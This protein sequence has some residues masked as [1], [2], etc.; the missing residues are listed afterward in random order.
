MDKGVDAPAIQAEGSAGTL[1]GEPQRSG[2]ATRLRRATV[3]LGFLAVGTVAAAFVLWGPS[4][5]PSGPDGVLTIRPHPLFASEVIN[6]LWHFDVVRAGAFEMGYRGPKSWV[7]IDFEVW[8][9]GRL[10]REPA[11]HP[12]SY[13]SDFR[14]K[15]HFS[16]RKE[17]TDAEVPTYRLR[18]LLEESFGSHGVW[19]GPHQ[20][21]MFD[22]RIEKPVVEPRDGYEFTHE[23]HPGRLET[24]REGEHL[25][26]AWTIVRAESSE[27]P[28]PE[29]NGPEARWALFLKVR[30]GPGDGRTK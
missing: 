7:S 30:C 21:P 14:L 8:E 23:L 25:L 16:L 28:S 5:Y 1:A 2:D 6:P 12:R 19:I 26:W 24:V 29:T 3:I 22:H 11:W 27:I 4:V 13:A 15:F 17:S 10:V 20:I 9:N 18:G